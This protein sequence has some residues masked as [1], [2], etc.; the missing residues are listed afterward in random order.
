MK[1]GWFVANQISVSR[2][3]VFVDRRVVSYTMLIRLVG[4]IW[5][6]FQ[7]I[8]DTFCL[9]LHTDFYPFIVVYLVKRRSHV[10]DGRH[11]SCMLNLLGWAHGRR[12]ARGGTNKGSKMLSHA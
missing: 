3:T 8:Y 1:P 4:P 7:G 5:F 12:P 9:L 10:T 6:A 2:A 11:T